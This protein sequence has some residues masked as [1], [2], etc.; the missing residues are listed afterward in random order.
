MGT[1]PVPITLRKKFTDGKE[2]VSD[3]SA[4][5]WEEDN[6]CT[7]NL[8]RYKEIT[9]IAVNYNVPDAELFNN[10]YPS[11]KDQYGD[12]IV[13]E[14]ILGEYKLNQYPVS[15]FVKKKNDLLFFE[16]PA[17]GMGSYILP[18]SGDSFESLSGSMKLEFQKE[19]G[20]YVGMNIQVSGMQLTAAKQ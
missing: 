4:K 2:E 5:T 19:N 7:I 8:P 15:A 3:W 18:K 13:L 12:F 20:K 17:A 11:L 16:I 10:Y 6:T 9:A 14:D 1:R